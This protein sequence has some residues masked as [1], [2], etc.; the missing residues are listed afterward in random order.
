M[1][2]HTIIA[3]VITLLATSTVAQAQNPDEKVV[4]PQYEIEADCV[5]LGRKTC[6]KT[7]L[8]GHCDS[9]PSQ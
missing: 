8:T 3:G 1:R 6:R 7:Q 4:L 5:H 2:L 9:A